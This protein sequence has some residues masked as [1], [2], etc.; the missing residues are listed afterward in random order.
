MLVLGFADS[1]CFLQK[2]A[3]VR[4]LLVEL[5]TFDGFSNILVQCH[6]CF[7]TEEQYRSQYLPRSGNGK[8]WLVHE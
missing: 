4:M 2:N 8:Y 5:L 6:C 1:E 7:K 3:L